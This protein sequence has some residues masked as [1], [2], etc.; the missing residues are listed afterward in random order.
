VHKLILGGYRRSTLTDAIRLQRVSRQ[1][2]FGV[3]MF[4]WLNASKNSN[5]RLSFWWNAEV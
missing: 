1:E 4:T 2:R 3:P 5:A